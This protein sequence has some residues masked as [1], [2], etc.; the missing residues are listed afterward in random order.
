MTALNLNKHIEWLCR[1]MVVNP[2]KTELMV[3]QGHEINVNLPTGRLECLKEMKVLGI[4]FDA[5][6][7]WS[8]Q[9]NKAVNHVLSK[10]EACASCFKWET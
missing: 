8:A 6:L 4:L 3:M 10:D 1:L 7:S 2:S 9:V 5:N